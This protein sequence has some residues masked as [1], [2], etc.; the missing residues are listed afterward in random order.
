MNLAIEFKYLNSRLSPFYFLPRYVFLIILNL[1]SRKLDGHKKSTI[2]ATG[3]WR[4][5]YPDA[6]S[7]KVNVNYIRYAR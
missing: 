6:P 7:E 3:F 5:H 2:L 4:V 1:F